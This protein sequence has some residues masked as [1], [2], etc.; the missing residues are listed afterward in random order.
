M[1][2]SLVEMLTPEQYQSFMEKMAQVPC[3]Y[4]SAWLDKKNSIISI[5]ESAT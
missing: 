4:F 3:F 1:R 2:F 5:D